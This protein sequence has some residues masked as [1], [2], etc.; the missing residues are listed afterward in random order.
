MKYN[1][2]VKDVNEGYINN[3]ARAFF[4]RG[5]SAHWR[6]SKGTSPNSISVQEV[7]NQVG[8]CHQC[9]GRL[10]I[11][12]L[13]EGSFMYSKE[14]KK[15]E[16]KLFGFIPYNKKQIVW[17]ACEKRWE[18]KQNLKNIKIKNKKVINLV[19]NRIDKIE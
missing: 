13:V 10:T 7:I 18:N 12:D 14:T 4:H 17:K 6:A 5:C 16:K 3:Y 19:T 1:I 8:V 15:M 11:D 2:D 9:G